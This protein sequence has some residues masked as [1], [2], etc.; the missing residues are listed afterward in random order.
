MIDVFEYKEEPVLKD[1]SLPAVTHPLYPD[2]PFYSST[3]N[4]TSQ[5]S[6]LD[7]STFDRPQDTQDVSLSS[8]YG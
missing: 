2:I 4:F 3:T 5:N 6:F 1:G 8:H 7:V